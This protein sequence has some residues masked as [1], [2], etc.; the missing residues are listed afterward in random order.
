M[1]AS[2]EIIRARP[3]LRLFKTTRV[4]SHTK[5]V[6]KNFAFGRVDGRLSQY[7]VDGYILLDDTTNNYPTN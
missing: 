2:S 3:R 5:C 4:E 1:R 6:W 7:K